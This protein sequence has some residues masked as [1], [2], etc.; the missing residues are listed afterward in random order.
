MVI[1]GSETDR[2]ANFGQTWVYET[3]AHFVE[4]AVGVREGMPHKLGFM[5]VKAIGWINR[6]G[7]NFGGYW[8]EALW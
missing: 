1:I 7:G 6:S 3:T 8:V 4:F 5:G 2:V